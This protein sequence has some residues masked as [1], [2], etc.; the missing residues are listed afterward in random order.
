MKHLGLPKW[1]PELFCDD[2]YLVPK[3]DDEK[4]WIIINVCNQC[5]DQ[6]EYF[7]LKSRNYWLCKPCVVNLTQE[8]EKY[9]FKVIFILKSNY[10]SFI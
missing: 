6:T 7:Y 10:G 5:Y 4:D 1:K 2:W 3:I 8:V 9:V